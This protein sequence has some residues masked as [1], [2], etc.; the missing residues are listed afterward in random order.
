MKLKIRFCF[1][2]FVLGGRYYESKERKIK[3]NAKLEQILLET[4]SLM[5]LADIEKCSKIQKRGAYSNSSEEPSNF[6]FC[7][8][9]S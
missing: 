1:Y 6:Q 2:F 9:A 7:L 3:I 8:F 4:S 5:A